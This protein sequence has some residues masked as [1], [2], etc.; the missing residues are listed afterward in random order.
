M[1]DIK[2]KLL[3]DAATVPVRASEGAAGYDLRACIDAPYTLKRGEIFPVPTGISIEL[4]GPNYV[5]MLCARSGLAIKHGITL[6]NS[7]GIIDSDYRGEIKVGL[8][9][10]GPQDFEIVPGE[11]VCQML[12]LPVE[13]PDVEVVSELSDTERGEGG[14]GSTGRK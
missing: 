8:I 4:P 7:V 10:L 5:A 3:N 1:K 9:N 11:R 12:I 14:F 6:A 2:I 13:L